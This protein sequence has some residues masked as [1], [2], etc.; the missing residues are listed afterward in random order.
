MVNT[1]KLL[2]LGSLVLGSLPLSAATLVGYNFDSSG[3]Y[4]L[5]NSVAPSTS[6]PSVVTGILSLNNGTTQGNTGFLRTTSG[7]ENGT[8]SLA[9]QFQNIE[10]GAAPTDGNAAPDNVTFSVSTNSGQFLQ[11]QSLTFLTGL[12]ANQTTGAVYTVQYNIGAG[13][14][15][16]GSSFT[17]TANAAETRTIDLSDPM[18]SSVS[19]ISFRINITEPEGS[20]NDPTFS[21]RLDDLVLNGNVIPEPSSLVLLGA[22][23]L[24]AVGRRSR[25]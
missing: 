14:V 7:P 9:I 8:A 16:I 5:P 15:N 25:R 1:S 21:A 2:I 4:S 3:G 19:S 17:Q 18:F 13:F 10:N 11:L 12:N 23:G 22:A 20:T 24:L 6:D